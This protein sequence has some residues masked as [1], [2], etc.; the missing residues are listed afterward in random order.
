MTGAAYADRRDAVLQRLAEMD[1]ERQREVVRAL[2]DV[3]V[4]KGRGTGRV[5]VTH[6]VAEHLNPDTIDPEW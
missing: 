2:V 3:E 5:L 6:K 1:M 4:H